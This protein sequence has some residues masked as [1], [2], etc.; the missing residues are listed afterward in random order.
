VVKLIS[1]RDKSQSLDNVALEEAYNMLEQERSELNLSLRDFDLGSTFQ[2]AVEVLV[3]ETSEIEEAED[4]ILGEIATETQR[5]E[6]LEL[7]V[8]RR[9]RP[10]CCD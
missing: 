3:V 9:R 7:K 1:T 5:L 4:K 6:E 8:A 10:Y 2:T